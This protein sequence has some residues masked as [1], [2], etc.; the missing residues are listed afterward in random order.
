MLR[1]ASPAF[2]QAVE[3]LAAE[4]ALGAEEI[5]FHQ[6]DAAND[7]FRVEEGLIEISV[8]SPDGRRCAL[9]VLGPGD[10]L[11][12]IALFSEGDRTATAKALR[13]CRLSRF[14]R[15]AL[16][17]KLET[18]PDL[19]LEMI[20]LAGQ[21]LKWMS[22]QFEDQAFLSAEARLA[23]KLLFLLD[24]IPT[25]SDTVEVSQSGL[26]D[27]VGVTR[28]LVSKSLSGWKRKGWVEIGRGRLKVLDRNALAE[29]SAADLD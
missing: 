23:R 5:L 21:R 17:S 16:Y 2:A 8:L 29:F 24:R 14:A 18:N 28:E 3:D 11:G 1:D 20:R 15:S 25:E 19:A 6:G 7:L 9:N 27:H 10:L 12:E 4:V 26:A 22:Q 13:P